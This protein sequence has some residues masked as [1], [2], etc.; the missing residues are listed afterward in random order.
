MAPEV[1]R[2]HDPGI[3]LDVDDTTSGPEVS[4]EWTRGRLKRAAA[5]II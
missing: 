2:T 5:K 3:A 1:L 4:K